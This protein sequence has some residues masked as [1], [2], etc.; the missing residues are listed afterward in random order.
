MLN[1]QDI[2]K[3]PAPAFYRL[4]D[5]LRITAL[6]RA[7][8][9]RRIAEGC[10]PRPIHLGGRACGWTPAALEAWI[11]NPEEYKTALSVAIVADAVRRRR[12]TERLKLSR[13]SRRKFRA[14]FGHESDRYK[15]RAKPCW[16]SP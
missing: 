8:I 12:N 3:K 9:Y 2:A 7:T 6:S 14:R 15:K 13:F 4:A 11:S 10:F 16:P 1:E 5:V